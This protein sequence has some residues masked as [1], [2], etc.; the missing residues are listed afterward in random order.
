MMSLVAPNDFSDVTARLQQKLEQAA[1]DSGQPSSA[2]LIRSVQHQIDAIAK[3]DFE[4]VL[5]QALPDVTLD[6]FA[7]P[8]FPWIRQGRGAAD[9]RRALQHNF[10]SVEDQQPKI[11]RIFTEGDTVVLFGRERGRIRATGQAYDVEFVEKFTFRDERLA[12]V[13]IIAAYAT[14]PVP[15]T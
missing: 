8:D 3:G 10:G 9:L 14:T 6:I 12:A 11:T 1:A 13:R 5:A 2:P 15:R 7:P 4:A